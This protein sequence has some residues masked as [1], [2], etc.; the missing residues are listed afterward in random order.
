MNSTIISAE[1]ARQAMEVSLNLSLA[2]RKGKELLRVG[3]TILEECKK[4]RM[5]TN[6]HID[7]PDLVHELRGKGYKVEEIDGSKVYCVNWVYH[8]HVETVVDFTPNE[9]K[10]G[11]SKY[12]QK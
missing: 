3:S 9:S 6:I 10:E 5:F 2:E 12:E 4:G 7:T 1:Q 11:E 8:T